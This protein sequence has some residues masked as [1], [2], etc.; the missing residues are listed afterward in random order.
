MKEVFTTTEAV[1]ICHISKQ[2]I[3]NLF[4]EGKIK[5]FRIPS[6]GGGTGGARRIPRNALIEF[7]QEHGIPTDVLLALKKKV[8]IVDDDPSSVELLRAMF[9]GDE[10]YE[11]ETATTGSEA[12]L[13]AGA[14]KPDLIL[15]DIMLPDLDGDA[16]YH[17]IR[18][19]GGFEGTKVV[20]V[21]ALSDDRWRQKMLAAGADDYVTK[22]IDVAELKKRVTE[23]LEAE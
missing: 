21:S 2:K 8:L 23:L 1:R 19:S 12:A 14:S 5:G 3:V 9:E 16:I 10:D 7:M 13:K 22:P 17:S 15:L 4:D 11:I 6:A 18:K 20:V